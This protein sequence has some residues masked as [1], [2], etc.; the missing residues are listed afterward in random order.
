M[1][2]EI[3][4]HGDELL[5]VEFFRLSLEETRQLVSFYKLSIQANREK[6]LQ[7]STAGN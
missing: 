1:E 4:R 5:Q 7:S 2:I 3:T 6:P